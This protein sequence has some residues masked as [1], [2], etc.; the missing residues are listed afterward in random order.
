ML[1]FIIIILNILT[2][3]AHGFEHI[4]GKLDFF[5]YICLYKWISVI[6][7]KGGLVFAGMYYIWLKEFTSAFKIV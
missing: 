1:V 7:I 2:I 6:N 5:V 4:S 3:C